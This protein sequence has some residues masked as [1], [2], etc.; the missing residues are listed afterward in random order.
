MADAATRAT[1]G[2][3]SATVADFRGAT[4]ASSLRR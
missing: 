4:A 3:Q 1:I 2:Y